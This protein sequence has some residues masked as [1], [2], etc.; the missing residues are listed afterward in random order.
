MKKYIITIASALLVIFGG[1]IAANQIS[2]DETNTDE[3]LV[4][5]TSIFPV[6]DMAKNIA[7]DD[8]EVILMLPSG[9][10][11]HTFEA[12]PK[13]IEE[14]SD[15]D[16]AFLI[17]HDL[18][19]WS[20]DMLPS[21]AKEILMDRDLTLMEFEDHDEEEHKEDEHGDEHGEDEHDE[22]SHDENGDEDHEQEGEEMHDEHSDEEGSDEHDHHHEGEDP[23]YWLSPANAKVMIKTIRDELIEIDS[24]NSEVYEGNYRSYL[25]ELEEL[26]Q[27]T[28]DKF[29]EPFEVV[30]FHNAFNY[31]ATQAGFEIVATIEPV[32]GQ[33][34]SAKYIESVTEILE[35]HDINE[36]F[37]EPQLSE[38][39][40]TPLTEQFQL[41]IY[42]IDPLGGTDQTS[43]YIDLIM[44]NLEQISKASN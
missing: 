38:N 16:L 32:A 25:T 18:D 4:I 35:D 27:Y 21:D 36:L 30:T 28:E 14:L 39:S 26:N 23:H 33:E 3:K 15:V 41:E 31:L 40:L 37:K 2:S 10:S 9:S 24:N 29:A 6:Y 22:E 8:V 43:T 11:P 5:A 42:T 12:T 7:G 34:A 1:L 20:E 13:Q 44:Y 17:G 19:I